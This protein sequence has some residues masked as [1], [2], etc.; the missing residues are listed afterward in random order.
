MNQDVGPAP[1]PTSQRHTAKHEWLR[2]RLL[3]DMTGLHPRSPLPTEREL[4]SRY[5]VSRAT[6][7]QA[8]NALEQ[9]G[10]VYRV[11]GAGTFV[12]GPHVSKSLSLTSFS[13]DMRMRGLRP[14]SHLLAADEVPADAVVAEDLQIPAAASVVRLVRVRLADDSPMCLETAY[15]PAAR[16]PGLL[17]SGLGTSLYDLLERRY[18]LR[19]CRADQ[20]LDAVTVTGADAGLLAV[21]PGAPALRVHRVSF[22]ERDQ[23]VERTTSLYRADRYD[24]QFAIRRAA[25]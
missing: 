4:A 24:M 15:L 22:D 6:V 10:T 23:S 13:E 9:S 5:E 7:R 19:L 18:G 2:E 25:R 12:A 1:E 16:V 11:Q 8:L 17:E 21:P 14:S 20:R 3:Q